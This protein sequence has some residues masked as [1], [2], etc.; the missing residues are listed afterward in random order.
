[1]EFSHVRIDDRPPCGRLGFCE[2]ADLTGNGSPDVIVG[3]MG[4]IGE[5]N[6]LGKRIKL[7][8]LPVSGWMIKHRES[9]VFWYENPGWERHEVARSPDLSVG[10]SVGD[11]DG[12]GEPEL[13]VGQ[14][15]GSE[16]YW[17][18]PP[19]DPRRSWERYLITD[20]FQ[21]YHDTAIADVNGD[22]EDEVLILSQRSE[23]ICYYDIP[24]DPTMS[25]WPTSHRHVIDRG[26]NVEGTAV[27][28]VDGDGIPE[29]IAG[30]HVFKQD[31]KD[32]WERRTIDPEWRWTRIAVAPVNGGAQPDIVMTEG[33]LPYQ[34][35]RLGRLGVVD[36][37][38]LAVTVLDDDL[39]CPHTLQV[40][41]I[42]GTGTLDILV[43]EMGLGKHAEPRL[44]CYENDGKKSFER[45][46]L[47]RGIPT[48]E[49]KL[50]DL[51]GT[52][53]L[54]IVSKSYGPDCHVDLWLRT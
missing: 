50:L 12:D 45:I 8:Q 22:G 18:D 29:V 16:L 4:R 48:H 31:G 13:V 36:P 24:A 44:L 40:G 30:P 3:G 5:V 27:A 26:L 49:A 38:T 20:D 52:G 35:D 47:D 2:P 21:K 7:R 54:D 51:T 6:L 37:E 10:G 33:D 42:T 32:K 1:M 34:E 9:N 19:P 28:D 43:G 39:F 11:I 46:E 15:D 23:V 41:D 17:F 25:P 14:N 53:E